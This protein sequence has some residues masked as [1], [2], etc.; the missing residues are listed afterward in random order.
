[1][2]RLTLTTKKALVHPQYIIELHGDSLNCP[3][4]VLWLILVENAGNINNMRTKK[5]QST[6][7]FFEIGHQVHYQQRQGCRMAPLKMKRETLDWKYHPVLGNICI[8]LILV[9]VGGTNGHGNPQ[10]Y[11]TT[12]L[13][14]MW[15]N[16][17][18]MSHQWTVS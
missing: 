12:H 6:L 8:W 2:R 10:S 14:F 16:K 3:C 4:L 9:W 11:S 18:I 13:T 7:F 5:K 15:P 17:G 1:M